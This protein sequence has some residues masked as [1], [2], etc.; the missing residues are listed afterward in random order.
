MVLIESAQGMAK[1]YSH[2]RFSQQDTNNQVLALASLSIHYDW[3]ATV[4]IFLDF[5]DLCIINHRIQVD[6]IVHVKEVF[7]CFFHCLFLHLKCSK[8][9]SHLS[10]VQSFF[11][12]LFSGGEVC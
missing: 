5:L 1:W 12:F 8:E 10:A 3:L 2:K 7:D 11:A 6:E 9:N 4:A